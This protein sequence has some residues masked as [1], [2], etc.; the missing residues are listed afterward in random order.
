MKLHTVQPHWNFG[1]LWENCLAHSEIPPKTQPDEPFILKFQIYF[2]DGHDE[3]ED[4]VDYQARI[5]TTLA[6]KFRF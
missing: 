3:L 5:S 4:L 2:E 1:Q 6:D